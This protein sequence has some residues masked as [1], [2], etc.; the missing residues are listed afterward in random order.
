MI[1]FT[2][3]L[4]LFLA[5]IY[6]QAPHPVPGGYSLPNGWR[7]T[8][9]G[10]AIPTE[11][12]ILNLTASPDGRVVIAQHGGFNPHGLLVIDA[13]TEEPVQRITLKSAWLGLAWSNDGTKLYVSGGNASGPK[14]PGAV[15]PIYVFNYSDGRLRDQPVAEWRDSLPANQTYWS[16]LAMHPKKNLLYAANRGADPR[17]GHVSVFDTTTGKVVGT[18]PVDV[19]PYDL[20]FSPD[21]SE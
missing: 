18:I 3:L 13:K 15:A 9:I 12:L 17:P 7:I 10:K 16:G 4:T 1:R 19:S 11:D 5:P 8:P 14:S 6:A 2:F 20:Q 21:G